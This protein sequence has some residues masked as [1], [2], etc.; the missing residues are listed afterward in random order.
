LERNPCSVVD[1]SMEEYAALVDA[2]ERLP[3][4]VARDG[5]RV[6]GLDIPRAA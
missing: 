1:Y 3:L 2:G 4:D 6:A 5:I